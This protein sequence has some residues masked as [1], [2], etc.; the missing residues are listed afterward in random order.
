M[1]DADT[2]PG[3]GSGRPSPASAIPCTATKSDRVGNTSPPSGTQNQQ[4]ATV[5]QP[6]TYRRAGRHILEGE[7]AAPGDP[8]HDGNTLIEVPLSAPAVRSVAERVA[9]HPPALVQKWLSNA[10][11]IP[12]PLYMMSGF[13]RLRWCNHTNT[14]AQAYLVVDTFRSLLD[15]LRS[16][17]RLIEPQTSSTTP[18]LQIGVSSSATLVRINFGRCTC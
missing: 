10:V 14:L 11:H 1:N 4:L 3:N 8:H 6:R 13:L 2:S 12:S 15:T 16:L 5:P 18:F 9:A 17:P 7:G